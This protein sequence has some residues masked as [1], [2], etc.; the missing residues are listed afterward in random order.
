MRWKIDN[1][2]R[3]MTITDAQGHLQVA[4]NK[5]TLRTEIL[6]RL[7]AGHTT[8]TRLMRELQT[9]QRL[10]SE[11][12]ADLE[13]GGHIENFRAL[14]GRNRVDLFWCLVGQ[15]PLPAHPRAG[16]RGAEILAAFQQA[17]APQSGAWTLMKAA[18]SVTGS[19]VSK[20]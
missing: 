11:A 6:E 1:P 9:S 14:S 19:K 3:V 18:P 12:M 2:A 17:A 10:M 7:A 4:R 8:K 16:F 20:S 13:H 5:A 15:R